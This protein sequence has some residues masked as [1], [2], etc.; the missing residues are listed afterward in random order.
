MKE[1]LLTNEETRS[2]TIVSF[3]STAVAEQKQ[4]A[5]LNT[6][7]QMETAEKERIQAILQAEADRKAAILEARKQPKSP[8]VEQALAEKY[9]ALDAG[10]RAFAILIDLGIVEASP[11]PD[12][13]DYDSSNDDQFVVQRLKFFKLSQLMLPNQHDLIMNWSNTVTLSE[14][15]SEP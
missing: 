6:R 4:R 15:I 2:L 7:L 14:V 1:M 9:G 12:S 5:I 13:K 10:E 8:E 3:L 11:D